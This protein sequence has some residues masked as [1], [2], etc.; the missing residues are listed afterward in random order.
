MNEPESDTSAKRA[1]LDEDTAKIFP[2]FDLQNFQ[3]KALYDRMYS[4]K[5]LCRVITEEKVALANSLTQGSSQG[6]L[7]ESFTEVLQT[8]TKINEEHTHELLKTIYGASKTRE[9]PKPASNGALTE[10]EPSKV[11]SSQSNF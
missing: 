7:L 4:Y 2:L 8:I 3:R 11:F 5:E 10:N 6:T 1:K 9:N